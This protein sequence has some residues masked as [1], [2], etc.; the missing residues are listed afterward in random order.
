VAEAAI[1]A[2]PDER[3]GERACAFVVLVPG[4]ELDFAAMQAYL[5]QAQVTR[6]YWPERLEAIDAL[7]RNPIGKVQKFVL[8][9]WAAQGSLASAH[10]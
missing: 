2:M 8:R 1:V 3:L 9:D 6:Q 4:G 5:E 10:G 7:P